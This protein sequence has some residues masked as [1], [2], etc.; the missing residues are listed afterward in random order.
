MPLQ[1]AK[2]IDEESPSGSEDESNGGSGSE[3]ALRRTPSAGALRR[4]PSTGA[5]RRTLSASTSAASDR[6]AQPNQVTSTSRHETTGKGA[7]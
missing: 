5:L 6:R 7:G 1:D 2:L 3:S 4:T